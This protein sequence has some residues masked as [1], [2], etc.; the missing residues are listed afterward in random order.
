MIVKSLPR[1]IVL[2]VVSCSEKMIKLTK[3]GCLIKV[4]LSLSRCHPKKKNFA[5]A[6]FS[7]KP[8]QTVH[9]KKSISECSDQ[10]SKKNVDSTY[11]IN[12]FKEKGFS[13]QKRVEGFGF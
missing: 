1:L 13:Q 6:L 5:R 3:K 8:T 2:D 12:S 9:Q 4:T 11:R 10:I 7:R